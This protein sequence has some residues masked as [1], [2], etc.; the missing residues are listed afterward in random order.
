MRKLLLAIVLLFSVSHYLLAQGGNKF[1]AENKNNIINANHTPK[2]NKSVTKKKKPNQGLKKKELIILDIK[3]KQMIVPNP[4]KDYININTL[5]NSL[6]CI[7]NTH[8]DIMKKF[9]NVF[10]ESMIDIRDL[11]KGL[12]YIK[13]IQPESKVITKKL[14]IK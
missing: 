14:E 7:Y 13:I 9:N 10:G 2:T 5:P 11:N 1:L 12:Y 6:I 4:A 3:E 8:G